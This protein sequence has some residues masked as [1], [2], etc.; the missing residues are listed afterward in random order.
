ML[1]YIAAKVR[2][3][4]ADANFLMCMRRIVGIA[5]HAVKEMRVAQMRAKEFLLIHSLRV[6]R[7]QNGTVERGILRLLLVGTTVE[8]RRTHIPHAIGNCGAQTH[9]LVAQRCPARCDIVLRKHHRTRQI[10]LP[11][12]SVCV[13]IAEHIILCA[14]GKCTSCT[15]LRLGIAFR[16]KCR[17]N[18]VFQRRKIHTHTI[19]ISGRGL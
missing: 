4:I 16:R 14:C 11:L 9:K 19:V 7:Q 17:K 15:L 5:R 1:Q 18:T 12:H 13:E 6:L 2:R 3:D 10:A 8:L